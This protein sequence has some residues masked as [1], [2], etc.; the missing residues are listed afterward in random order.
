MKKKVFKNLLFL[1]KRMD[2]KY[3]INLL[4]D[5]GAIF[6][7]KLD[8]NIINYLTNRFSFTTNYKEAYYL[9]LNNL[10]EPSK[11]KFCNKAAKFIGYKQGYHETCCNS[12]CNYQ[13][14][15]ETMYKN[16]GVYNVFELDDVKSKIKQTN[17]NK[18][19]V[20]NPAK[21]DVIKQKIRNSFINKYNVTSSF[22]LDKTS[23]TLLKKYGVKNIQSNKYYNNKSNNTKL[24]KYGSKNNID[25]IKKTV[26]K[27]YGVENI[28]SLPE[29]KEKVKQTCLNKYGVECY[30]LSDECKE[31]CLSNESKEK[32]YLTYK[33]NN[34]FNKSKSEDKTY[35]ILKEKYPDIL[36]QYRSDKYP[37]CCDFYIPSLDLYIECNYHWTHGGKPFE[38]T[39][40]DNIKLEQWKCKN[41]K[42]YNNAINTWTNLDIRK[43]NV[44]LINNL[45]YKIFY[46]IEDIKKWINI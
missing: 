39:E 17:I 9:I 36:R 13:Q 10:S 34:S 4:K 26:Y 7:N 27:K 35:N 1:I 28:Y 45:N 30:F 19:G 8:S 41:T 25:K 29:I 6:W 42:Y 43:Y 24:I 38:G 11:C 31:K 44:A 33:K 32:K 23:E 20:D 15:K 22:Q 14:R 3:V 46:N 2:D 16:Y 12:K 40:E 18:Y 21:N 5:K 37:F